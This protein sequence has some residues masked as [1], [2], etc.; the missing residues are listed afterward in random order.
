[1]VRSDDGIMSARMVKTQQRTRYS[2]H[3]MVGPSP[4]QDMGWPHLVPD[5]VY[6][7]EN[8]SVTRISFFPLLFSSPSAFNNGGRIHAIVLQCPTW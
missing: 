1:M 8:M 4:Y 7:L 5:N 2:E 3:A 6:H